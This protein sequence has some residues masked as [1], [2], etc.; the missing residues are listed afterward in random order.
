MVSQLLKRAFVVASLSFAV[1]A[2]CFAQSVAGSSFDG[3]QIEVP[4]GGQVRVENQFGEVSAEI[5]K[6]RYVSVSATIAGGARL[7]RSPVVIENRSQLLSVRIVR[8]PG[9]PAAAINLAIKLPETVRVE[10]VTAGGPQSMR[11]VP[12]SVSMK[13]GA[14]NINVEFVGPVNADI[15]ARSTKGTVRSELP[16]LMSNSGHVLQ[17][18][19]G[20][21]AQTIRINSVAGEIALS[22]A[23]S[24]E[25]VKVA[26]R[27]VDEPAT[28]EAPT[29]GAGIPAPALDSEEISEGDI[30]RVDS[31]MVSLNMSVIDRTT[32]RGLMGLTKSDFRLFENGGEQQILQFESSSAPFDLILLIDL[33]GST[34][35]V[36]KLIRAAALRFVEAARPS[37]R[38]GV[39]TFAGQPTAVSPLTLDRRLLRQRINAMETY[40]NGDTKLYDAT[41]FALSQLL[42]DAKNR[43]RTA[44]VLMSDGLD[45]TIPGVSGQQGST[46]PYGDLLNRV[47]E[48]DGVLYT[49]WLNTYYEALH[50]KDTQPEAFDAGHDRLKQMADT[51]GGVFYEVE[52]L[53]D[54]AGAY[55]RV[56]ADLGTVYTLAYR[57]SDKTRDGKWRSIRVNVARPSAVARGK[58]GYYAN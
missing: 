48:F 40:T 5:W 42:Q 16:Q 45:G 36:V 54:L 41:D 56:V 18:R 50:P 12:K 15:A 29:K 39:I 6:E 46:L 11:G 22:P 58:R 28:P 10:I 49:I 55:E 24:P 47:Q 25:I 52:S 2:S 21:G 19:V 34:R 31:Q 38:I 9:D 1:C 44:V 26:R 3:I 43:R 17:A 13:S 23:E 35:D 51:G 57:P 27:I 32:N 4:S 33:S 53:Q 30:I 14:G 20:T 8:R 37:D 7:T